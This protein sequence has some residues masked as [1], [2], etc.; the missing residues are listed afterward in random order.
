M[1]RRLCAALVIA[2][3]AIGPAC[4][5]RPDP[6]V[7]HDRAEPHFVDV[8]SARGLDFR[9]RR[10]ARG[11]R[12]L[13]ETMGGGVAFIDID[14]DGDLDVFAPQGQAAREDGSFPETGVHRLFRSEGGARFTD[15]T[16][17]A[18]LGDLGGYGLG[19]AVGDVDND[20]DSD[21]YLIRYGDNALLLNEGGGRFVEKRD[22]GV[23]GAAPFS[24]SAAFGDLDGDG[25]LDLFLAGY[26]S[27]VEDE[28]PCFQTSSTTGEKV[29]IYCGPHHFRG[30][31]DQIFLGNGDGTFRDA[32]AGAGLRDPGWAVSKSLGVVIADLDDDRDLDVFVACDTTANLLYRNRGDATFEEDALWVGVAASDAGGYEGGMGIAAGDF[33]DDGRLDLFVTNY[34]D[35][36]NRLYSRADSRHFV[37]ATDRFG[38]G[39][40][41]H[42]N[43]GWGT[44]LEDFDLDGDLDLFVANGHIF[45]NLEAWSDK[46]A[47]RQRNAFFR[48]QREEIA[49]GGAANT[50]E[51]SGRFVDA[52]RAIGP[53]CRGERSHRGVAAGDFDSD[54][55]VDLL[56]SALDE[57]LLLFRNR[58][59]RH[60][61]G[62]LV[63]ELVGDGPGGR[64]AIGARVD[65]ESAGTRQ[66]R[67]RIGGGSYL[68]APD[69]RLHFGLPSSKPIDTLVVTWPDGGV[70]RLPPPPVDTFVRI[71]RGRGSAEIV[72]RRSPDAAD[73]DD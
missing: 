34:E 61:R 62:F 57:P 50:A 29:R 59:A 5:P 73:G 30:A 13:H 64:D 46:G 48:F 58:T 28:S 43:V 71:E 3:G 24:A 21:L 44:A 68:S 53:P 72:D 66:S 51:R 67:W 22:A 19:A 38:V 32:T 2:I 4:T 65:I 10:G 8:A 60:G 9:H 55:R 18:G 1:T 33:D 47:Y 16:D 49:P 7:E 31:V 36:S 12:R 45:D 20:G 23:E 15:V 70:E 63:V 26:V 37:D 17:A 41:S 6:S 56:V 11:D 69:H 42:P 52:S 25:W 27:K 35:E 39:A 40:K 14:R 54:G